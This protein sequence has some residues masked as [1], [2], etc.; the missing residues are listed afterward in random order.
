MDATLA[1]P[2]PQ[3][4]A[5]S[6]AAACLRFW[7]ALA[8]TAFASTAA[9]AAFFLGRLLR[10]R[11]DRWAYDCARAWARAV[12]WVARCP[13]EVE[14][15]APPPQGGFV[16]CANHQ[17]ILDILALFVALERTPFVFA[18]KRGL[19]SVP[20]IGWYLRLADYVEVDR[21]D[22]ARAI[23]SYARAARQVREGR[24]LTVYPEGTRS[25]DGS[26][27]PFKKGV[28]VLALESQQPIVPVAVEGAQFALRKHTLRLY[29]HP[30]RVRV[31]AP[32]PTRG[33]APAERDTLLRRTRLAVLDL[34]RQIGGPPSPQDPMVAPPGRPRGDRSLST[35]A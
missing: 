11:G 13:V 34:H 29:G 20:V 26:V 7:F 12:L 18:A 32:I 4:D 23:A 2:R 10:A 27:L 5:V 3:D 33:L 9:V 14:F 31:G 22:R 16:Y 6:A 8:F 25:I 17:G 30:I 15:S 21:S 35:P 19:F 24:V 1:P 28:F